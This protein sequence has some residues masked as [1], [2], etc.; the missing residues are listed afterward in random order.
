MKKILPLG[1]VYVSQSRI[2][3]AG[4]GVFALTSI[5]KGELIEQCPVLEIS[6]DDTAHVTEESLVTYMYYFDKKSVVAL[7]FG[8]IYNHT[9]TPNA[10]YK[11]NLAE[12]IIEFWAIQDIQK[13]EE[14]TVSYAQD[15]KNDT[16]PLWF[17]VSR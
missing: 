1:K 12:K 13:N 9:D 4:R 14:I 5:Q 16:T 8:S 7:G 17:A 10:R 3:H 11:E 15:N 6:E 2:A